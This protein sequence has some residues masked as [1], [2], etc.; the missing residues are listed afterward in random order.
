MGAVWFRAGTEWVP[1]LEEVSQRKKLRSGTDDIPAMAAFAAAAKE[2]VSEQDAEYRRIELFKTALTQRLQ[3]LD[4][5]MVVEGH[6]EHSTPYILGLR[7]PGMEGQFLMLECSQA[8]LA[9]ST[10]S[11]CQ[12]GIEAPNRTMKSVGRTD[13]QAREFVRLSFGKLNTE[14]Q[15]DEIIHKIDTILSR[16]FSKVHR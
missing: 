4:Y 14:S 7:F 2:I 13:E 11:A 10:G 1:Y 12:V 5:E 9:I 3:A 15:L 8:G 16:H 6:P